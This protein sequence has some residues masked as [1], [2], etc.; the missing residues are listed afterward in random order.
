VGVLPLAKPSPPNIA[1]EFGDAPDVKYIDAHVR[2]EQ[3]EGPR[4]SRRETERDELINW[5]HCARTD[6]ANERDR[7]AP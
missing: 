4:R 6:F 7:V 3:A 5:R 2:Q 1:A